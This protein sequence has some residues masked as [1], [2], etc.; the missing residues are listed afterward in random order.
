M[1]HD[2]GR[3]HSADLLR[4]R[5]GTGARYDAANAP[6]EDL[7]LLRRGTAYFA[8]RLNELANLDLRERSLC[9]NWTRSRLVAEVCHHARHLAITLKG[10]RDELTDEE[11]AWKPEPEF[12]A[13]LPPHA[14]RYLYHHSS[15]HLNVEFRDLGEEDW[16]RQITQGSD[17]RVCVR[18]LPLQRAHLIWGA[19]HGLKTGGRHTDVP[20]QIQDMSESRLM[21]DTLTWRLIASRSGPTLMS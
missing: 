15:I 4:A 16:N 21:A 10:L 12:A 6:H 18:A 20:Q 5:Q 13:T 2:R 8:R 7:L 3:T 14:L 11:S 1:R 9:Q 17:R 19:A